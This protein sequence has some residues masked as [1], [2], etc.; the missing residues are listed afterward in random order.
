M[1]GLLII[2][3]I[4]GRLLG[5]NESIELIRSRNCFENV[6]DIEGYDPLIIFKAKAL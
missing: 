3:T 1:N 5:F 4:D 6:G 2:S